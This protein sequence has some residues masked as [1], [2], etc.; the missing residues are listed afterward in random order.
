MKTQNYNELLFEFLDIQ[1]THL[2][3]LGMITKTLN[4]QNKSI[5]IVIR[6]LKKF[7]TPFLAPITMF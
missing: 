1:I 2:T 4:Y 5:Y 6:K 3:Q 7:A